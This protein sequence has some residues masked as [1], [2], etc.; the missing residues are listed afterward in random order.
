M[1]VNTSLLYQIK[2][3]NLGNQATLLVV[4]D[5]IPANTSYIFGSASSGGQLDGNT[6]AWTL[7]VLN[8]G[9]TATLTFQ[10]KVLGGSKIVNDTYAVRCEEGVSAY[11]EPV[12][13]RVRYLVRRVMLPFLSK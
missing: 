8:H 9:D 2:V 12:V 11:G 3:T 4:T 13:T 1:L 7:P 10:V 6:V 5:T